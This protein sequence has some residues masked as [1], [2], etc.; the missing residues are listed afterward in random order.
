[1]KRTNLAQ[2]SLLL[3]S[4][5]VICGNAIAQTG[6][7]R[8]ANAPPTVP[9]VPI[10]AAQPPRALPAPQLAAPAPADRLP[11]PGTPLPPG[12]GMPAPAPVPLPLP[13]ADLKT[14]AL[15]RVAPLNPKEIIELRKELGARSAAMTQ[16]LEPVGQPVRRVV[17]LDLTPGAA[18]GVIRVALSQGSVITFL[19]ATGRPWPVKSADN[20]NPGGFD[21][22]TFGT[23]GVSI[24]VK[25][26][27]ARNGNLAILL[28]GLSAPVT[29]AVQ[30]GQ[31]EIDYSVEFHVQRLLPGTP[32]PAG[33]T[34]QVLSLGSA[35]LMNFLLNTP[36]KEAR[37]LIS[38]LPMSV[39]AWQISPDRMIVR[40]DAMV[41][42]PAW[43]RR[44]SSAMGVTVYDMPLSPVLLL[45]VNGDLRPV[46]FSGF[47]ATKEQK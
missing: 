18:P 32:A 38:D 8:A 7:V 17:K 19:D 44:Q 46:R 25:S 40:T 43:Q 4:N 5:L 9:N 31:R 34:E 26:L 10:V 2:A 6:L 12:Y 27:S 13:P 37:S 15:D 41:A 36:P 42:S 22:A 33:A 39:S 28:D 11:A 30:T 16:P 23:N 47:G 24:G 29:L 20:F 3:F 14:E 21:I 35:D 45:A 1:M